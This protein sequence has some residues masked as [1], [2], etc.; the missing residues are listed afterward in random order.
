VHALRRRQDLEE[1]AGAYKDIQRV[2]TLQE[3]LV[4]ILEIL[5]PLAVIKG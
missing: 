4:D 5:Q 3:D 2:I 1:A